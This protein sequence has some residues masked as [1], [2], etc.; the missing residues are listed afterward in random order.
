MTTRKI[1]LRLKNGA[2][3][4][5]VYRKSDY[6]SYTIHLSFS[7]GLFKSHSYFLD[8]N[9]VFDEENYKDEKVIEMSD[10]NEF[11]QMLKLQFP[12]ITFNQ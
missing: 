4:T 2:G 1:F 5:T 9:D 8:G 7:H 3:I 12:G 11:M 10:F 6:I